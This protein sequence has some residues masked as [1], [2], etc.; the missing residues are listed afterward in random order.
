AFC[1]PP[2]FFLFH[3]HSACDVL[4]HVSTGITQRGVAQAMT[5]VK[6]LDRIRK[7][8][9]LWLMAGC[10]VLSFAALPALSETKFLDPLDAP[11]EMGTSLEKRPLMAFVSAGKRLV[12]VG[13]RGLIIVSD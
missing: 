11:A 9:R 8:N 6:H 4:Q 5:G 3:I 10:F 13:S 7:P 1:R 12:A 2:L